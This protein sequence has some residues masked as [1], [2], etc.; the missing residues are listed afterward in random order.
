M[1]RI[2]AG[3]GADVEMAR[4]HVISGCRERGYY[5]QAEIIPTESKDGFC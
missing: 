4:E 2:L 3:L 1:N 5:R